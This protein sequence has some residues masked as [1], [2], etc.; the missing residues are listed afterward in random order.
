MKHDIAKI[1][2]NYCA[3]SSQGAIEEVGCAICAQLCPRM[4]AVDLDCLKEYLGVL[5]EA[6][7]VKHERKSK[8]NGLVDIPGSVLAPGL[9]TVCSGC[10]N[11]LRS[12]K[13]PKLALANH[14]WIGEVLDALQNLTLAE[15]T[16]ISRVRFSQL[17]IRVSNGH[18]KMI[19]NV[20]VF[21]HPTVQI[22]DKLPVSHNDLNEIL[23]VVFTGVSHPTEDDLKQTPVLVRWV[24]MHKVLEWLTLNHKEYANLTIDYDMLTTYGDENVPVQ[25]IYCP[26]SE[27]DGNT[28]ATVQSQFDVEERGTTDGPCPFTI[29]GL[30]AEHF[31]ALTTT[32]RKAIAVQHIQ[33]GGSLLAVGRSGLQ[34]QA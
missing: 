27:G 22:Y 28:P 2:S 23:A 18:T 16:M 14:L 15:Q 17:V 13:Q 31:G 3:D 1:M 21:E 6:D 20:I 19:A 29:H 34:A 25:V 10:T 12:G 7:V 24:K 8:T 30:A 26:S 5:E 4:S 11:D 9:K 33:N 32:Q